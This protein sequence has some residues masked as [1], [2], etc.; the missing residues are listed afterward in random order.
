[1]KVCFREHLTQHEKLLNEFKHKWNVQFEEF[2]INKFYDVHKN[3]D[4][5]K[6]TKI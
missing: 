5:I 6:D 2:V 4:D 1:M 3:D